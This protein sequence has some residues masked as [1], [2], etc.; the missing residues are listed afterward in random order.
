MQ[1]LDY[2]GRVHGIGARCAFL[3][4]PLAEQERL[5]NYNDF[6]K[7]DIS[8]ALGFY[9]SAIEHGLHM[10]SAYHH[11]ISAMHSDEDI[12][13]VLERIEDVTIDLKK[14]GLD[15]PSTSDEKITLF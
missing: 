7:N 14:K 15:R 4:G 9:G 13:H 8:M 5:I 2:P 3:F 1:R 11:G 6:A 10:H 12:D